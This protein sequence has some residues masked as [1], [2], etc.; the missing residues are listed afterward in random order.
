MLSVPASALINIKTLEPYY[1]LL[2]P[3]LSLTATQLISLHLFLHRP[4]NGK[5][6]DPLFGPYISILPQEF[7]SHPLTWLIK[8]KRQEN[9]ELTSLNLLRNLSPTVVTALRRVGERFYDDWKVLRRF[10][11]SPSL[12]PIYLVLMLMYYR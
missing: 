6:T 1:R 9:S 2:C 12:S 8:C 3:S 7:E 10:L 5:S 4:E 11:V